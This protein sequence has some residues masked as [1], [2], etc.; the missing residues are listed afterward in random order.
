MGVGMMTRKIRLSALVAGALLVAGCGGGGGPSGS[1]PSG[2]TAAPASSAPP[3][4]TTDPAVATTVEGGGYVSVVTDEIIDNPDF[5]ALEQRILGVVSEV[6]LP[7]A[8]LLVVHAGELVEQQ[9]WG[10]YALDTKVP[11]ASAS[12]WF[13]GALLMTLVDEG[14]LALDEPVSTYVEE[15]DGTPH[16]RITLR[17]MLSFTTGLI[18][19]DLVPCYSSPDSTLQECAVQFVRE[20]LAHQPGAQYRYHSGHLMM[21]GALAEIVTGQSFEE[22]FQERIAVPLGMTSTRF[23]HNKD[24]SRVP[25]TFPNPAGGAVSTLGDYARFLEMLVNGG[26]APDGTRILTPESIAE[27]E[28]NQ[29][30]GL[31]MR[32]SAF[33]V[34]TKAPYGLAHWI[35]WTY[36]DGSTMVDSSPGKFGFRGWIDREN[37]VFGVYM[38]VD[39]SEDNDPDSTPAGGSW[40]YEMSAEAVGGALPQ[41]IY[42]HR[43]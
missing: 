12:K 34:N 30:E 4:A 7:G 10:E 43:R 19:D 28:T 5:D 1:N 3:A 18:S 41:A 40:I 38:V 23:L 39:Q 31:P 33:R 27:M 32:G 25:V 22:L 37:D 15:L 20:R 42:P 6:G 17:Q 35:D 13:S 9:T 29:T 8:S 11:I 16:G 2:T 26:L 21:A 24:P 36:P 14:L